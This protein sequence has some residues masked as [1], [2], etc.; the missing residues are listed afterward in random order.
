MANSHSTGESLIV[1][2]ADQKAAKF[3]E[4]DN[5]D[6]FD[7][8]RLSPMISKFLAPEP[9]YE[10]FKLKASTGE[11]YVLFVLNRVQPRPVMA[12]VDGKT[13]TKVH[14]R[15]GDIWIKHNTALRN[16]RKE[17]LDLMYEPIIQNEAAKRA[18]VVIEHLKQES[19]AANLAPAVNPIPVEEL[20]L[21]SRVSQAIY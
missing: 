8:A 11:Q 14:F 19:S 13:D 18:R 15:P 5:A 7:P 12:I 21:G 10:I 9:R 2:G 4:V 6:D 16:A 17:D 3:I 1:I 20:L